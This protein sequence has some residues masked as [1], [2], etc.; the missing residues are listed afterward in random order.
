ATSTATGA[1]STSTATRKSG[2]T[3]TTWTRSPT[4]SATGATARPLWNRYGTRAGDTPA[5]ELVTHCQPRGPALQ[6]DLVAGG[7]QLAGVGAAVGDAG[8]DDDVLDG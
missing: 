8:V 5:L 1:T 4:G 6:G 3:G 2:R 7:D